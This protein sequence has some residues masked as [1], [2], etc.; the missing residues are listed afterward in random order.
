MNFITK[1]SKV[2]RARTDKVQSSREPGPSTLQIHRTRWW[3]DTPRGRQSHL[4][5]PRQAPRN[6]NVR[7]MEAG[8][9]SWHNLEVLLSATDNYRPEPG[10]GL[11]STFLASKQMQA[12]VAA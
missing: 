4:P 12:A 7:R 6:Q 3:R 5:G 8:A 2:P 11:S 1:L 10:N 9:S